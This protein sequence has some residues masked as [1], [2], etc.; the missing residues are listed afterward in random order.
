VDLYVD[1]RNKGALAFYE[2]IGYKHYRKVIN[3]Y[4]EGDHAI[5]MHK[6]LPA[7]RRKTSELRAQDIE[8][9]ELPRWNIF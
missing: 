3:Y 5:D 6:A 8:R 2:R 9:E 4:G 1:V 7:D